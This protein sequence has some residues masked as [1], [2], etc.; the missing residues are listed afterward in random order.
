MRLCDRR[1]QKR[2]IKRVLRKEVVRNTS[3]TEEIMQKDN[4]F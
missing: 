1:G 2:K 3:H 4:E